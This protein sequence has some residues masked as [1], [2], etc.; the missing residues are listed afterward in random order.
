MRVE[1]VAWRPPE[2]AAIRMISGPRM[3]KRFAGSWIFSPD[4]SGMVEVRFRY[5]FEAAPI[6][7]SPEPF[8]LAYFNMETSRRLDRLK[9]YLELKSDDT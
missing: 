9:R 1:Y 3:L 2:R 4:A 8:M 5:H 7:R 6:W